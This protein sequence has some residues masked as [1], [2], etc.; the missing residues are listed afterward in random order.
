MPYA[1][2]VCPDGRIQTVKEHTDGVCQKAEK[3]ARRFG[4]RAMT[5]LMCLLHD[6]GKNTAYSNLYQHTVG[7]GE[8]WEK[9]KP[10][11]SHAGARLIAEEYGNDSTDMYT[12]LLAELSETVIMAHHG[13]FDCLRP[14]GRNQ[15]LRKIQN[16]DYDFTESTAP[17]NTKP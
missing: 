10:I 11:H 7:A 15:L 2:R 14:D 9:G 12:S 17:K 1:A 6:M 4:T 16:Q 5:R 13:L 8:P 3:D